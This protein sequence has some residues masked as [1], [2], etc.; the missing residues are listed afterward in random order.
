LHWVAP[1]RRS[2]QGPRLV[3]RTSAAAGECASPAADLNTAQRELFLGPDDPAVQR[4]A[5]AAGIP[6]DWIDAAQRSPIWGLINRYQV[7]LPLQP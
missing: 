4:A 7:A 1:D 3:T 2:H 6:R 5:E